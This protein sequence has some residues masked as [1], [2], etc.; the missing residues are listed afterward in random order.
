[1][2]KELRNCCI[3][4]RQKLE[5][6]QCEREVT[7]KIGRMIFIVFKERKEENGK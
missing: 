6:E 1:M 5:R 2:D 7:L 4:T 3:L